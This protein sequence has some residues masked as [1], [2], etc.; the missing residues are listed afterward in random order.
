MIYLFVLN[1]HFGPKYLFVKTESVK[2]E[3]HC[4]FN[5]QTY[6]ERIHSC[7]HLKNLLF[8]RPE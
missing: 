4:F 8:F 3:F 2:T 1:T 7:K 6:S 5:I